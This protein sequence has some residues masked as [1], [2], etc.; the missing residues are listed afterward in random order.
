M[1]KNLIISI[2]TLGF[3]LSACTAKEVT[4]AVSNPIPTSSIVITE[5]HL[6]PI[7]NLYL[8]F[9]TAGRV[10]EILVSEGDHVTKGTVL[11]RLADSEKA[12]AALA[13]ARMEL[14]LA[15]QDYDSLIRNAGLAHAQ[16][17]QVYLASQKIRAAAKLA[18]DRLDLNA[19]Q[20]DIDDAQADVTSK[21][22][23]LEN[24]QKEFTK[25]SD[26]PVNNATRVFYENKVVTAQTDYDLAVQKLEE[27][28]NRR[29]SI[30]IVL[31][32]ALG[33]E[34]EA[35]RSYEN[36]LS[37]SDPDKLK[38][39]SERLDM[40]QLQ[41]DTA[42]ST[43]DNYKLTA[44]FD[45][46]I[47]DVNV[48]LGE[49]AGPENYAV[50][51]ADTRAWYVD[52]SDLSELDV[53]NISVGQEVKVAADSIPSVV[54]K[55]VVESINGAPNI[56]GGDILYEVRIRMVDIDPDWRWGMTVEVTFSDVVE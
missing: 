43:L 21:L 19:I 15:Q 39:A 10:E 56:Q 51:I 53:V 11:V 31:D 6:Y 35:R 13:S 17:W 29:D 7:R 12:A 34:S 41:M 37:G 33:V 55:G 3:L 50:A 18:W 2:L 32:I 44:S 25:Y 16:A 23:D 42:Q 28:I 24:A 5:G 48:S 9:P 4:S 30:R 38:L 40:A 27:I 47:A 45:G 49:W 46:F 26:L 22:T 54:M 8:V 1:K 14:T 36:T 20:I 52:T